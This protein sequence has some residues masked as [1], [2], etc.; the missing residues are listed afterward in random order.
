M[1]RPWPEVRV[2]VISMYSSYRSEALA[3]GADRFLVKG[4]QVGQLF[5]ALV[6]SEHGGK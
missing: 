4:G 2:V 3:A 1:R 5:D 6:G